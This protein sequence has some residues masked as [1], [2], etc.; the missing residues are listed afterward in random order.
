MK[1]AAPDAAEGCPVLSFVRD[2]RDSVGRWTRREW[3]RIGGWS[4]AA[5]FL[6]GAISAAGRSPANSSPG[7]AK[8]KSVI[9]VF[10]SGGQSQIDL[11]DPKPHA[12]PEVRG[13]FHAI[14]TSVPGTQL[15]EHLPRVAKLADRYTIVR[16]M[17]HEDLDHGSAVYLSFTGRYHSR[18][19]SNP[20]PRATDH[21]SHSAV[22]KRVRPKCRFAD[23]AV[24]VNAPAIVAPNDIAPG[25]FGGFLG[26]DYDALTVGNVARG[27]VALPGLSPQ[28]DLTQ[29]RLQRRRTLL[30]SIESHCRRFARDR[31]AGDLDTLYG[32]AFQMLADPKTKDAFDLGKEPP[33]LRDRYGRDRSG[34]SCLLARRL[35]EAGVPLVTVVWNHHSRGQDMH[36]DES[37]FYGWD[38]HNDI[39]SALKERL[40]PRFDLSFSALLED[41]EARGLLDST[42]VVCMGEFGRAPLVALEKRFAG[43]SPGRKHWA[44]CYS[45]VFAGAGVSR[46]N[47]LGG[48]DRLGAY[49]TGPS[50]G[51][52]DINATIFSAL[53]IDPAS[54][55]RDTLERPI[56]ISIGKPMTGLYEG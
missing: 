9:V 6:G 24:H 34:Q 16:S 42:L 19:S 52:W 26:R 18:K 3:L 44:A 4:A 35:V 45:V 41:L 15:C 2:E 31:K 56:A 46:G 47:I 32:R 53:G 13:E 51:P 17:S 7:F 28:E 1:N 22:L 50:F 38:T 21:P 33:P 27:R 54:H 12:P 14:R 39:F 49:P 23:A 55:F 11:W 29:V 43:S 36:P 5:P 48:S 37:E 40:L 25:Q 8:A 20:P 10:T 30:Q